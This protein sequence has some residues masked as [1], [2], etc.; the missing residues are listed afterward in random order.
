MS[1]STYLSALGFVHKM[2]G[3]TD[4][5]SAFLVTK[6]YR[7]NHRPY[8]RFPISVPILNSLIDCLEWVTSSAYD[9]CLFKAM[10]LLA[11][12]AFA[13]IGE[14][15]IRKNSTNVL[16]LADISISSINGH[17]SSVAVT[18]HHF[19]HNLSG[20]PHTITFGHG[21][22]ISSAV[23]SLHYYI[24]MRGTIKAHCFV[25]Q[26]K[27]WSQ[28]W[29]LIDFFIVLCPFINWTAKFTRDI[30]FAYVQ[31]LWLQRIMY[32]TRR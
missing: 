31:P 4:P 6:L 27:D 29:Y 15:T 22:T 10:F 30:V 1:F 26:T 16:Q 7:L 18:F 17:L 11:F 2:Q 21:P 5:T 12:N 8:I 13:R 23:Q 14:I 25:W 19:K 28:G 32:L 3:L 20:P 9:H 24:E